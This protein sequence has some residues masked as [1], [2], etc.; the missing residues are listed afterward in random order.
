M[1][2]SLYRV[3][4]PMIFDEI[5]GQEHIKRYFKNAVKNENISHAY[6][7]SGPRGTGKTTTARILSK[8]VNCENP[9][10][11]NPCNECSNCKAINENNFMDVIELD[12]AS[13]RGIDEI[14]QIRDSAN[15]RPVKGKY[16]VYIIDEI[17]MLTKEAFNALLKTLEEPP[18]HVIF[19]LATTN[20]EKIPDT[21]I[22]RSQLLNF[23][24]LS[25]VDI[26]D[27]LKLISENEKINIED[28]AI[29]LI[30]RKAKGGMRDAISLLEQVMK[31]SDKEITKQD[32]V[33]I[34]GIYDEQYIMN[35][36]NAIYNSDID[37]ILEISNE[38]FNLGKDPELLVEESMEKIITIIGNDKNDKYFYIL[39]NLQKIH[40]ELK[41]SEN[42]KLVF[43][44]M[45]ATF[46]FNLSNIDEKKME[47]QS[48]S[49]LD[50]FESDPAE[51]KKI[52][53][54]VTQIFDY[55]T[56]N[57]KKINLA[58]VYALKYSEYKLEGNEFI[59]KIKKD[60][61]LEY[62]LINK[63]KND[64][65]VALNNI[66]NDD[67]HLNIFYEGSIKTYDE[68]PKSQSK[69]LF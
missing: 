46:S 50:T 43:E 52:D 20:L 21:I 68:K 26:S 23:R 61:S 15:Y 38:I 16:K 32:I 6:I 62:E 3:Y 56:K 53:K 65:K 42:T 29:N 69:Q 67:T 1:K 30:S 59:I 9:N 60:Q 24:N 18:E 19:V 12:A 39:E 57:Q 33:N 22:S 48:E 36:I 40:K 28:Q 35:F 2:Q 41:Y 8:I 14:R 31:F 17:H 44:T 66:F 64:I 47:K 5:F 25:E 34:L 11:S 7:F 27:N 58:I 10:G 45:V 51:E 49:N 55:F 54:N 63:Y 13:N 4:R 37:E